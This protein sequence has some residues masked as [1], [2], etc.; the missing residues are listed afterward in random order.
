MT[1]HAAAGQF[2]VMKNRT[3]EGDRS[4]RARLAITALC[5]VLVLTVLFSLTSGASDAS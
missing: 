5:V 4:G 3:I 1:D 2:G